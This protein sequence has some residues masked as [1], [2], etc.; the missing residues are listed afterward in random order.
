MNPDQIF[1]DY[2]KP[3][4]INLAQLSKNLANFFGIALGLIVLL[5]MLQITVSIQLLTVEISVAEANCRR[6]TL[7][8]VSALIVLS[9]LTV[10][11]L[12]FVRPDINGVALYYLESIATAI[13]AILFSVMIFYFNR[14]VKLHGGLANERARIFSQFMVFF[15]A[16]TTKAAY[17]VYQ[18]V[19][20]DRSIVDEFILLALWVPWHVLPSSFVFFTHHM[21][22]R[23]MV[24]SD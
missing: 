10:E 2:N 15:L 24:D 16:F 5:T 22:Y 19:K 3:L 13:L 11:T 9:Y 20:E 4:D 21:A 6:W 1:F 17:C 7:I 8:V 12:V 18:V 14:K 23:N